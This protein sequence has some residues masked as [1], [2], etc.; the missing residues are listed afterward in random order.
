MK[1]GGVQA[2]KMLRAGYGLTARLLSFPTPVVIAS[3]GLG[4]VRDGRVHAV[5]RRLPFWRAGPVH[6][7]CQRGGDWP[8]DAARCMRGVLRLRLNPAARERA[9]TL[10]EQFSPEQA[11]QVGFIDALVPAEQLLD[12]ARDK[13]VALLEL[14]SE[15]HAISKKRLRADT[16][17]KIRTAL[18][19]SPDLK[20]AVVLG[21]K[22]VAKARL[23]RRALALIGS[24]HEDFPVGFPFRRADVCEMS[25][26]ARAPCCFFGRC[27][28]R[29]SSCW[30]GR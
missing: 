25:G 28:S 9:V 18:P 13:A 3:P 20:D 11:L 23:G 2:V 6:V 24:S 5:V 1:S 14:D 29:C 8:S 17:R 19:F 26:L 15:A 7:R 12:T 16:L 22:Q 27:T 10:S 21:A 30:R 4:C